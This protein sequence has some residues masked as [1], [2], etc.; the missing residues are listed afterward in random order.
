MPWGDDLRCDHVA[1]PCHG[2]A[3]H[4]RRTYADLF[5][6]HG[7]TSIPVVEKG[8]VLLGVIFQ[9]DLIRRARRDAMRA[10]TSF[11]AAW[12]QFDAIGQSASFGPPRS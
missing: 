1:R 5:R 12:Q 7:F 6:K 2:A 10:N 4:P 11:G 9:L 3:R 8:G